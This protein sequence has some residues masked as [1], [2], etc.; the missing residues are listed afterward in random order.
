MDAQVIA[1]KVEGK[2]LRAA[3][4]ARALERVTTWASLY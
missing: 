4:W 3:T 1:E 2:K